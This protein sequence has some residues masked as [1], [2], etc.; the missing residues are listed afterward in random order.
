[1]IPAEEPNQ[2][3][4][5]GRQMIAKIHVRIDFLPVKYKANEI[6]NNTPPIINAKNIVFRPYISPSNPRKLF[7]SNF[8]NIIYLLLIMQ[9]WL[10]Q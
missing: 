7:R 2:V 4:L 9:K 10:V 5:T 8:K 1:M 6:M 3:I